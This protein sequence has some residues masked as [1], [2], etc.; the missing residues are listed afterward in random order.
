MLQD[1]GNL[2]LAEPPVRTAVGVS[3]DRSVEREEVQAADMAALRDR[4]KRMRMPR[5]EWLPCADR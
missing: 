5:G 3:R 4:V 2:A 1:H